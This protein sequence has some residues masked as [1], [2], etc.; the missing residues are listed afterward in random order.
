MYRLNVEM[1]TQRSPWI[2]VLARTCTQPHLLCSDSS[3]FLFD[4]QNSMELSVARVWKQLFD[5][6][7]RKKWLSPPC[8]DS[9]ESIRFGPNIRVTLVQCLMGSVKKTDTCFSVVSPFLE[10]SLISRIWKNTS[11]SG[12]MSER[13]HDT[14]HHMTIEIVTNS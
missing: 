3:E 5:S 13:T 7:F 8:R 12:Y 6:R 4:R 9:H 11:L 2:L 14:H 1:L 10:K